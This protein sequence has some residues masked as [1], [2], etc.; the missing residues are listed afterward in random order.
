MKMNYYLFILLL[1]FNAACYS[2]PVDSSYDSSL[3]DLSN[4]QSIAK[5]NSDEL[6]SM[7]RPYELAA[8]HPWPQFSE[9]DRLKLGAKNKQILLLR[10]R[11]VLLG[12][13][14]LD[15]DYFNER[16]DNRLLEAVK[17]F[18]T[19]HGLNADGVIGKDT[20][21]AL[22]VLPQ[23]RTKQILANI[24]RWD[25]L[26]NQLG[27]RFVMVNI[28]DFNLFLYDKNQVVF[29][30]KTIVGKPDWPTPELSSKITTIEFNP[31][32]NI[33]RNIIIK[34]IVPKVLENS[35]Y[36]DEMHIRAYTNDG[37][38]EI[39]PNTIDWQQL[40][41]HNLDFAMQQDSGE[42]NALGLVRFEFFNTHAVY[43][44]DTP[45]KNLFSKDF[46]ALSHGCVRLEQPF[47]LVDYLMRDSDRWSQ[48]RLQE[49]IDSGKTT[50]INVPH[51]LPVFLT[52][53]TAWID[54]NGKIN[55]RD[56]IYGL[57]NLTPPLNQQAKEPTLNESTDYNLNSIN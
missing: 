31:N 43:L 22:N 8:T 25:N 49:I 30:M 40:D 17:Q 12:D 6:R 16:F 38:S 39:D 53:L 20:R 1:L 9:Q 52:Y 32:W 27:D 55:F 4:A 11:L 54:E 7:L 44:H 34:D 18:Q 10:E 50:H 41:I 23:D 33:P 47:A 57:D 48:E 15:K 37:S 36:L 26:A 35:R 45:A 14:A 21:A 29:K 51:P 3:V 2:A 56:D 46:R 19:R 24:H 28:P 13:I 42:N 5:K